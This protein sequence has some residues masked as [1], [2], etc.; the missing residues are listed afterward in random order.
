MTN[1]IDPVIIGGVW[2]FS[3]I[4]LVGV[5]SFLLGYLWRDYRDE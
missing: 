4:A 2:F 1:Y 5:E 3:I